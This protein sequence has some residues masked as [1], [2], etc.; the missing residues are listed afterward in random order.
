MR[1]GR[2]LTQRYIVNDSTTIH[3][4]A[5]NPSNTRIMAKAGEM[6][7]QT[8]LEDLNRTA[9]KFQGRTREMGKRMGFHC[10]AVSR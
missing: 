8:L 2:L 3:T 6:W 9:L 7:I 10:A 5:F 4:R 1:V